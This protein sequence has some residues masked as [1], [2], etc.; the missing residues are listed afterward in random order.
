MF[1]F[2]GGAPLRLIVLAA[3]DMSKEEEGVRHV[4]GEVVKKKKK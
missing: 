4:E 3:P 1:Q 2:H